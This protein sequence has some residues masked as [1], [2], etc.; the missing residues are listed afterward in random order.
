M[1]QKDAFT[2]PGI[3][4]HLQV[5][6]SRP[7]EYPDQVICFNFTSWKG[8]HCDPACIVQPGE[9]PWVKHKSFVYYANPSILR[10]EV[11]EALHA[12]NRIESWAPVSDEV[13]DR[14]LAGA[15]ITKM[16]SME[17]AELLADQGLIS[18]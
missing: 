18:L 10:S 16:L 6:I 8:D 11:V 13:F 12:P 4:D 5:V 3:N 9:H 17:D 1:R 2:I 7:D 15:T 14:M